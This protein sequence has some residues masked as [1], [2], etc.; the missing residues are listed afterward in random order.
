MKVIALASVSADGFIA[1]S[2]NQSSLDWNEK[3]D[4]Q[5][6]VSKTKEV[7][8]VIMGRKT[9]ETIGRP[10]KGRRLIV[11]TRSHQD[12]LEGVEFTAE[13][14]ADLLSRLGKEGVDEVVV[15]GGGQ[16]YSLFFEARLVDEL[17]LTMA[18]VVFG[19]GVPFLALT[20]AIQ[21]KRIESKP[22][23]EH[24]VLNQYHVVYE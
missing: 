19:S 10:L 5:F 23:G 20:N 18:P 4:T 8:V 17:F 16:V 11:M 9:W 15:A 21:L 6:F 24:S 7:G 13:S 14:P 12:G 2:E 3:A 1:Q 22:L